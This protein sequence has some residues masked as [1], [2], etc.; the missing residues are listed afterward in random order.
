MSQPG[1]TQVTTDQA[2]TDEAL[3]FGGIV[4]P[5]SA[6]ILGVQLDK[7]IDEL[8]RLA[9]EANPDDVQE[10]LSRSGFNAPLAPDS[11]PFMEPVTGF[12]LKAAT[13]VFSTEDSLPPDDARRNTVFRRVAVDR[14]NPTKSMVYLWLFTT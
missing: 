11:G 5:P 3:Q 2:T 13:V 12:D 9:I 10:L 6:K 8:Y 7:G 4:L 14:S 1:S